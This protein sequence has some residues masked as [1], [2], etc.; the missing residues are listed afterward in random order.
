MVDVNDLTTY[1][2]EHGLEYGY[3]EIPTWYAAMMDPDD[4][5]L[6]IGSY[7][8]GKAETLVRQLKASGCPDAY[9]L[10]MGAGGK[11]KKIY[12]D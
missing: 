5:N 4:T 7:D 9:I 12:I 11:T 1:D 2:P 10:A 6:T 8:L 3:I